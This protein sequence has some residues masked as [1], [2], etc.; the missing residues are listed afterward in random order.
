MKIWNLFPPVV[1]LILVIQVIKAV[2][3]PVIPIEQ[4]R[5]TVEKVN[6]DWLNGIPCFKGESVLLFNGDICSFSTYSVH[7]RSQLDCYL[8][9]SDTNGITCFQSTRSFIDMNEAK[10]WCA[11][12]EGH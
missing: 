12:N 2:A 6:P 5:E 8:R 11:A 3:Y 4:A 7:C 1:L 10:A 9:R